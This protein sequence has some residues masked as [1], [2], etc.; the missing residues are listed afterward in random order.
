MKI[1]NLC[2]LNYA[3]VSI[4]DPTRPTGPTCPTRQT[5]D[6]LSSVVRPPER[7]LRRRVLLSKEDRLRAQGWLLRAFVPSWGNPIWSFGLCSAR[8][9]LLGSQA[10]TRSHLGI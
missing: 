5:S 7:F 8:I 1:I 9:A 3:I 6:F 10:P 4:P 2:Y